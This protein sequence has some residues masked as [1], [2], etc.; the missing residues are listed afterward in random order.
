LEV[1]E[2]LRL[3]PV[4]IRLH[5][6]LDGDPGSDDVALVEARGWFE[7]WWDRAGAAGRPM[8]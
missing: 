2:G 5:A 7:A 4:A 3:E 6:L 8:S 1:A